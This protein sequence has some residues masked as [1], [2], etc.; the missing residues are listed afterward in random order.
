MIRYSLLCDSGHGF[1][2]WFQGSDGFDVQA[3]RGLIAC[4]F[5]HSVRVEK[6]IMAPSVT[7]TDH[8]RSAAHVPASRE[9]PASKQLVLAHA[10]SAPETSEL[11][12]VN[13]ETQ[14]RRAAIKA[15]RAIILESAENVGPRFAQ[16]A[17]A[18][19]EGEIE[20]RSIYGQASP[21]EVKALIDD[22]IEA[23]PIPVLPEDRN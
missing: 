11:A 4:P 17:R 8:D 7:R 3:A 6:A 5:C 13:P 9:S 21:D 15:L 23:L 19:H 10:L 2:G 20:S 12:L 22:G 1:E 18:M 16:E 14:A